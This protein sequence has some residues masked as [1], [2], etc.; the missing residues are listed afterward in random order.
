MWWCAKAGDGLK[1][2]ALLDFSI[3]VDVVNGV[4]GSL[5]ADN[6]R[7]SSMV[8]NRR[9]LWSRLHQFQRYRNLPMLGFWNLPSLTFECRRVDDLRRRSNFK[10]MHTHQW[11]FYINLGPLTVGLLVYTVQ[12]ATYLHKYGGVFWDRIISYRDILCSILSYPSF[13]PVAIL[14]HH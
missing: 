1:N 7:R 10:C 6:V 12:V 9:R 3:L 11:K 8:C 13:F 5:A 4:T 2:R 14:C